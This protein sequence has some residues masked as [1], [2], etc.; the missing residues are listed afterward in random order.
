MFQNG[1]PRY[2]IEGYDT[3]HLA[4]PVLLLIVIGLLAFLPG[5]ST[6]AKALPQQRT[7]QAA[8]PSLQQPAPRPMTP[9]LWLQP[10]SGTMVSAGQPLTVNGTAEPGS[11][12]RLFY[13]HNR[14]GH[15]LSQTNATAQGQWRFIVS[16]LTAGQHSFQAVAYSGSRTMP[17]GELRVTA[18]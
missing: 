1:R 4:V 7:G 15:L 9:T 5:N 14:Q 2:W 13:L 18:K 8:S 17:S 6:T 16:K 3:A 10:R 12:V 11:L